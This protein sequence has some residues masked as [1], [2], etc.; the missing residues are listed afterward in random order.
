SASKIHTSMLSLLFLLSSY[1]MTT[2][3]EWTWSLHPEA[4]FKVLSPVSLM[5]DVKEVP[6]PTGMIQYH[7]YSGGSLTD[8]TLSLAIVIDHYEL[9]LT[10]D[11]PS[12]DYYREFF[13]T[14]IDEI[15]VAIDGS[16]VYS[17]YLS[18]SDH[19]EYVWKAN[20]QNGKDIV[21]GTLIVAGNR[22]YGLQIFG[23]QE[24]YPDE[25]MNR[26]TNSFK[27]TEVTK[28]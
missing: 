27:L 3:P 26:F 16:L 6:T 7:Q 5:H 2:P 17:D 22:Y 8:S 23:K 15:L 13:E 11:I 12:D 4:G 1:F 28:F 25:L 21:K 9:P 20:Y 18:H 14:T 19:V 24:D 10:A